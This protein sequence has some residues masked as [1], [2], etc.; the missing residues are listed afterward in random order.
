LAAW[1]WGRVDASTWLL[2]GVQA[3]A[4][5]IWWLR[6][7][8]LTATQ[9][10][11]M[12]QHTLRLAQ[13][14][15]R[16]DWQG[17]TPTEWLPLQT[18]LDTMARQLSAMVAQVRSN[19]AL[20]AE[21]GR[22]LQ[23]DNHELAQR[24]E[25]Q[26]ASL[27]QTSASLQDMATT[28]ATYAQTAHQSLVVTAHVQTV[29]T[30]SQG[31]MQDSVATMQDIAQSAKRMEDIVGV[32]DALAFQTNLL[33][34][35]ASIEAARAGELGRGFSVVAG[36]VRQL[37]G[38]SAQAAKDIRSLISGSGERVAKGV[39]G[40][41]QVSESMQGLGSG[42]GQVH[43]SMGGISQAADEQ[44]N[45]LQQVAQAVAEMDRITQDNATMVDEAARSADQL[46]QRANVLTQSVA[47]FELRQGT[48]DE[49]RA[50]VE[51]AATRYRQ[52]PAQ[53]LQEFTAP[54][55]HYIDRDM[56]VFGIDQQG[57]YKAWGG[58]PAKIGTRMQDVVGI[59]GAALVSK[60]VSV[61]EV[62]GGWVEYDFRN[63]TT[64]NVAPK[65]SYVLPCN[66]LY[67]GCGVYKTLL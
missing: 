45:G 8:Q 3:A 15:L 65:M 49:A 4:L 60:I 58:Q 62:G 66:G 53:A 57:N 59:D 56:Y 48:A 52:A 32:M 41:T 47:S 23:Q 55:G 39:Q 36:E 54:D 38:R 26:A 42:M 22:L 16:T 2:W 50:I 25:R 19:A 27:E 11:R 12:A 61:G 64:G 20:V 10:E 31:L 43:T 14:R 24:T 17:S 5:L 63:P 1:C 21:S 29:V 7:R 9:I 35:N 67:L 34:I 46:S 6:Q 40:I 13:G 37:A 44:S 30:R 51:R 28:V 33:S 18:A